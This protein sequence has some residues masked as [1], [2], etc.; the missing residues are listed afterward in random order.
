MATDFI[1]VLDTDGTPLAPTH[2]H[3]HTRMLLKTGQAK[4][5]C[6]RPYTI[7]LLYESETP[8]V[9]PQLIAGQDPGRTNQ[10]TNVIDRTGKSVYAAHIE[11]R[12]KEIPTLMKNRSAN[13]RASRNGERARRIRKAKLHHTTFQ[14]GDHNRKLPK[15]NE[16]VPIHYIINTEAKFCCRTRPDGWLT[17]T[18]NQLLQTH[19][20]EVKQL[21][22]ILPITDFVIELN[23]FDFAKL[24]DPT[25][26]KWQYGK[27]SLYQTNLKDLIDEEQ[28]HHCLLCKNPI[29]HYHHIVHKADNGSD[30]VENMVG[31]C[32]KCHT[33]VHK[34]QKVEEKVLSK[35]EGLEKKFAGTSI[36]NQIFKPYIIWLIKTFGEDH[37]FITDGKTTAKFRNDHNVPKTHEL[38][39]Y[40]IACSILENPIINYDCVV[41]EEKQFRHHNR[42][43]IN[44][45]RERKYYHVD[46]VQTTKTLKNGKQVVKTE[47]KNKTLVATNRKKRMDQ[48]TDSLREY[49]M[50]LR[51]KYDKQTVKKMISEL[52]VVKST[53]GYRDQ[54]TIMPGAVFMYHGKHYVLSGTSNQGQYFRAVGQGKTNFPTKDCKIVRKNT[55]LVYLY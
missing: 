7:Q 29:E 34:N 39:A 10:G 55:G 8:R 17:P 6:Y 12:N 14:Y 19:I 25:L 49:H 4:V 18:A 38:D 24:K 20:S 22:K 50:K 52:V 11:T 33:R 47:L 9:V 53:R 5:V 28:D 30:T 3:K 54:N 37:V 27:G 41:F 40:C 13:R 46:R 21:M 16:T 2:R 48:K 26:Q 51:Q 31:L 45:T 36:L 43:L 1:Y 42:Q 15:C 23:K 35:K 44:S 32:K